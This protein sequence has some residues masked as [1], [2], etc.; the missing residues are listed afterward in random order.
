MDDIIKLIHRRFE[1]DDLAQQRPIECERGVW[2]R[3]ESVSRTE[4][5]DA[6]VQG[7][8][9]EFVA[10]M[11]IVNYCGEII[12]EYRCVRYSVYRTY[13]RNDSDEIELYLSREVGA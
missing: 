5:R 3:I 1:A 13:R 7:L 11:P 10:V 9:A 2:C 12:A 8:K 6:G 4:W